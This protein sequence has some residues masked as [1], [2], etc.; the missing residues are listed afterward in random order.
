MAKNAARA[1]ATI[2]GSR[3]APYEGDAAWFL[4]GI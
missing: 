3:V 4:S 1:A 2:A